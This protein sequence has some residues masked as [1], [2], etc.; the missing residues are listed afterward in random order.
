M[1]GAII[2]DII[3]SYYEVLEIEHQKKYHKIRPYDERMKIMTNEL[4]NENSSY[5]DD[6]VLTIAIADAIINGNCQYEKYLIQYGLKEIGI[7]LDKYGRSRFG[8]GFIEWLLGNKEGN[9]FGNG[10]AMRISPVGYFN[11]IESVKENSYYATIPS[12][13]SVEAIKGAECIATS[14]YLLRNGLS[15]E[16]LKKYVE[17]NYYVLNYN[18][19]DLRKNNKFSSKCSVTVPQAIYI[20]L[21]SNS[22]EDSIRKAISI[23]GD[24]DTIAAIVGSISEAYYE[25][26]DYLIEE[27]NKYITDDIKKVINSFYKNKAKVKQYKISGS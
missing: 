7:G 18:L 23:G 2:G 15:K 26:P 25:I 14:I 1:Y 24:A 9:S 21:E 20:F 5:T 11:T 4:F 10:A 12:H 19:E 13:N 3:G 6:T 16:D 27:A 17:N 8:K 22:F